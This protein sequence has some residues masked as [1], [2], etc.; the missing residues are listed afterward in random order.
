[1]QVKREPTPFTP[2]SIKIES[3][4][5]LDALYKLLNQSVLSSEGLTTLYN[6]L[7]TMTTRPARTRGTVDHQPPRIHPD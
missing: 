2:V 1:M 4:E 6:H 3:Q 5:E 7:E